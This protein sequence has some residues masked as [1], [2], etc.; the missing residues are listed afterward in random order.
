MA[1]ATDRRNHVVTYGLTKLLHAGLQLELN[2]LSLVELE[3]EFME[4]YLV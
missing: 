3:V 1:H 4:L 2:W